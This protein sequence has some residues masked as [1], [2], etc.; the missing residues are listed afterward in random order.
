MASIREIAKLAGVSPA[1]VSRVLNADETMSVS[2]ATRTRIIKVANQL[3]YHKVENLG[4]KSPKQSNKLSIAVIKTHSSKRENDDPY[5]RLI[6]EGI[7]LETGNWNFRLETLKLGEVSLEQLA[8]FGAVLTIGAFTD[9]TLA[10]IYKVNQNLIVVDNHFASSRYDLVHTDFAK[11]TE[12]VLDYLY[13]QGH[14]QIAFI[15][16][17]I[18]TVDLKGQKQHLLADVRTTAYENWM[19]IH[20]LSDKIQLKTGDWSMGF[21]LNATNALI[22][23]SGDQLPTAIISASDPMSIG[24]Y[25]ALQLKNITIPEAISVFSFDDIEMVGYLSPPLSTV[26]IDSLEIG[27]VAVRLAKERISDGRKTAL[28]VEVASEIIVRESVRKNKLS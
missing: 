4:P 15:G 13:E 18:R 24:I 9:E 25:R 23:A 27:R 11:Q 20:G 10:D 19:T 7:A 2:P 3:N 17:E 1:T 28:R 22:E 16:G 14:R 8:Q 21:A 26:H 5:F 6:Q 12:Q